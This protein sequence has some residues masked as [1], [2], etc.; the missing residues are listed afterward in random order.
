MLSINFTAVLLALMVVVKALA[1]P[2]EVRRSSSLATLPQH[3]INPATRAQ[4]VALKRQDWVYGPPFLGGPAF[5]TGPLAGARIQSNVGRFSVE[6]Y[7]NN[8]QNADL[9]LV[10]QAVGVNGGLQLYIPGGDAPGILTN[11]TEDL[12]FS[13][14]RLSL[15]P[16]S[17]RR[18]DSNETL[19]FLVDDV[20]SIAISGLTLQA[21]TACFYI[22]PSS[23][24]FLPLAIKT[25]TDVN[26]V[27]TSLDTAND[28]LFAKI[29]FNVNDLFHAQ[30]FHL[31]AS[32]DIGEIVH[33]AA[34]RTLSDQHPIVILLERHSSTSLG[35]C[36]PFLNVGAQVLFNPGGLFGQGFHS[37]STGAVQFINDQYPTHGAFQGGF[38]ENDLAARG[39]INS[40]FGP[41]LNNFPFYDDAKAL[42][43]IIKSFMQTF[44]NTYYA[45]NA[46]ML[47]DA[48]LQAW[49][50]EASG[51]S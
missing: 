46:D 17:V 3:A 26:L 38:L 24:N 45:S 27:Y 49:I 50:A 29:L 18:V 6:V 10:K 1:F 41:A 16:Y 35:K 20:T 40:T 12:L 14:E 37:N 32:H 31:V 11:Y 5:P 23:G 44:V 7:A 4:A 48:E 22:S 2:H 36:W 47:A 34:M 9:L 8:S 39:L 33:Q 25:N 13:M 28:W 42:K 19:P 21:C 30:M 43:S 15:N 51:P